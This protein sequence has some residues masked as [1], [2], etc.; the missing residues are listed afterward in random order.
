MAAASYSII[1]SN[2]QAVSR[3]LALGVL[4]VIAALVALSGFASAPLARRLQRDRRHVAVCLAVTAPIIAVT[5]LR[6]GWPR[7]FADDISLTVTWWL[8]GWGDVANDLVTF[9]EATLN[10]LLFVPAGA[11]WAAMTRR[12]GRTLAALAAS[13]FVIE[14]VQALFGLGAPDTT[15]LVAN[16]L[17]AAIGVG[18]GVVGVAVWRRTKWSLLGPSV[19]SR[20]CGVLFATAAGVLVAV[21]AAV[22][23]VQWRADAA[24]DDL[25]SELRRTYDGTT[26]RD[27]DAVFQDSDGS[28]Q[29]FL[30]RNSVRPDS[31][32]SGASPRRTEV[33]YATMYFGFSRCVFVTWTNDGVSFRSDEGDACTDFLGDRLD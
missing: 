6:D 19:Q 16:T 13:S 21:V 3:L 25:L 29:Q 23:I 30:D 5:L 8:Q 26:L 27:M 15:D 2:S 24:R 11:A 32:R 28:Y 22:L 14:T 1:G 17:G 20:S 31:Q 33:R 10:V 12:Y 7:G 18:L 9:S 4:P